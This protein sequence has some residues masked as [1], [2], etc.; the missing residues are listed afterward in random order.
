MVL[1]MALKF[2]SSVKK[3]LEIK[4]RKFRELIPIFGEFTEEKR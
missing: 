4:V 2:H 1:G 3:G